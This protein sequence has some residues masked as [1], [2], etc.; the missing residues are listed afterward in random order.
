MLLINR[1]NFGLIQEIFINFLGP[2]ELMQTRRHPLHRQVRRP[3][4]PSHHGGAPEDHLPPEESEMSI[5]QQR[6]QRPR[7]RG[8]N[9]PLLL[10]GR[11][12]HIFL[13]RTTWAT[14]VTS[15]YTVRTSAAS[16]CPGD[17]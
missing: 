14:A 3:N 11:V 5:L 6:I 8:N 15:P 7:I 2:L 9:N 1:S 4:P 13:V 12:L 16:K 17:T 10:S